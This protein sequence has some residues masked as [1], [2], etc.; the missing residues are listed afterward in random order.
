[1]K[2]TRCI[3]KKKNWKGKEMKHWRKMTAILSL[4]LLMSSCGL[5]IAKP[6]Y[7]NDSDKIVCDEA[8]VGVCEKVSFS[9]CNMSKGTFRNMTGVDPELGKEFKITYQ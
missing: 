4:S 1:M 8:G 6:I 5:K 3:W 7:F 2:L 9:C